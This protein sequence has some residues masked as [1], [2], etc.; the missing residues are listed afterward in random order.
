M[1]SVL[2]QFAIPVTSV[3][4]VEA[5]GVERILPCGRRPGCT[6]C[7][8]AA[9]VPRIVVHVPGTHSAPGGRISSDRT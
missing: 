5:D 9:R 7:A 2:S 3:H 4:K 1:S 6:G 8:F